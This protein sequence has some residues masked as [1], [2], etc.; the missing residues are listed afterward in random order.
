MA[1]RFRAAAETRLDK[2]IADATPLSR[3]IITT[4]SSSIGAKLV[5][6]DRVSANLES[7][8]FPVLLSNV[9]PARLLS[10]RGRHDTLSSGALVLRTDPSRII[11]SVRIFWREA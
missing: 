7:E 8:I 1:Q 11:N 2:A 3:A 5:S 10:A 9:T 6:F 4:I